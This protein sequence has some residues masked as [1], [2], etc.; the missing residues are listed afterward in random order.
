MPH[1]TDLDLP[2]D[3]IGSCSEGFPFHPF[4]Y[5]SDQPR[6]VPDFALDYMR[7][8]ACI[9]CQLDEKANY[10]VVGWRFHTRAELDA[11]LADHPELPILGLIRD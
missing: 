9:C 8:N 5:M 1:S 6:K 10:T 11:C 2:I 3:C 7:P 4:D